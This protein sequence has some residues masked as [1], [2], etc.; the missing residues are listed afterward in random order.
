MNQNLVPTE[1]LFQ[2][3]P[4]LGVTNGSDK[5]RIPRRA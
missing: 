3:V 4:R 5:T 2:D 1:L